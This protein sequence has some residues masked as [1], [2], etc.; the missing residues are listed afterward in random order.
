M[1]EITDRGQLREMMAFALRRSGR[2]AVVSQA[3]GEKIVFARRAV[4]IGCRAFWIPGEG[5]QA[6]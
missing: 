1:D 4:E 2:R 6:L 3:E 5:T